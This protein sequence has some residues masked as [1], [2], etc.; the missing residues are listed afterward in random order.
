MVWPKGCFW[1]KCS[2][3]CEIKINFLRRQRVEY[4]FLLELGH[5]IAAWS[6]M[7]LYWLVNRLGYTKMT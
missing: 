3:D 6:L 5:N 4:L 2:I 1:Y 7:T